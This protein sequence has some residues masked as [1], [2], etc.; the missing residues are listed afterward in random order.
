MPKAETTWQ[1]VSLESL[2]ELDADHLF[3]VSKPKE[4]GLVKLQE[5]PIYKN[6][7][8]VKKGNV[9]N[10]EDPSNWTINGLIA[11]E[12]TIDAIENSLTK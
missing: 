1:P 6:L 10:M 8:S 3:L 9:Y 5:S 12:L 4:S 2:S 7:P 11:N